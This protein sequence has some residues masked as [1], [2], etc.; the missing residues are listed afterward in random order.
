ML[1]ESLEFASPGL[2]FAIGFKQAGKL[3][4][5]PGFRLIVKAPVQP[6][7]RETGCGGHNFTAPPR[8]LF[9]RR[10]RI[11]AISKP[12]AAIPAEFADDRRFAAMCHL[13]NHAFKVRE[14][15]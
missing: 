3:A 12:A 15:L 13:R 9:F 1:R 7:T 14:V 2:H 5:I 6:A 4:Y 11:F 10:R 8:L